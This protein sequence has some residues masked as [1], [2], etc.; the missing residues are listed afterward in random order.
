METGEAVRLG[1]RVVRGRDWAYRNQDGNPPGEGTV[2]ELNT[3]C[4]G[5]VL[6]QWDIG[7]HGH[8]CMGGNNGRFDLKKAFAVTTGLSAAEKAAME[9][10]EEERA[11]G[12]GNEDFSDITITC[13]GETFRAH[14]IIIAL[15][16]TTF[17]SMFKDDMLEGG[18]NAVDVKEMEPA[19]LRAMLHYIYKRKLEPEAKSELVMDLLAASDQ[20]HVKGLSLLCQEYVLE[21]VNKGLVDAEDI[22]RVLVVAEAHSNNK[23]KAACID[24]IQGNRQNIADTTTWQQLKKKNAKLVVDVLE[25]ISGFPGPSKATKA[26][27]NCRS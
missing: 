18:S 5:G 7:A 24:F 3:G 27:G 17:A 23:I 1:D 25:K 4:G 10:H 6:V 26:F 22:V 15:H 12:F 14:K 11:N 13:K 9:I 21:Q 16:S 19:V 8:Y 2:T 20:Y